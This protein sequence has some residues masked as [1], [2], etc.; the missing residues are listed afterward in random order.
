MAPLGHQATQV[1]QP[2]QDA[3]LIIAT[4]T[5]SGVGISMQPQGT[6]QLGDKVKVEIDGLG[7]IEN[8]VIAEPDTAKIQ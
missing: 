3:L 5:P 8:E 7:F 6:L 4:G 1:P 2:L